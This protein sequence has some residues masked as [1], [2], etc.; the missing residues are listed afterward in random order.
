EVPVDDG[1]RVAPHPGG[2]AL[3]PVGRD[4]IADVILEVWSLRTPR[5][6]LT[7]REGAKCWGVADF[8]TELYAGDRGPQ[9]VRVTEMICLDPNGVEW[10]GPCETDTPAAFRLHE[11][12]DQCPAARRQAEPGRILDARLWKAGRQNLQV[13][14]FETGRTRPEQDRRRKTPR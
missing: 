7:F 2:T 10:I 4:A 8:P 12:P 5:H 13:R 14:A 11:A 1:R 6:H 3:M 9:I